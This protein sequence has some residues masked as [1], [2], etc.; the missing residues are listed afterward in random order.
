MARFNVQAFV[1]NTTEN[2]VKIDTKL[3]REFSEAKEGGF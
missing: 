2:E 3:K 1:L